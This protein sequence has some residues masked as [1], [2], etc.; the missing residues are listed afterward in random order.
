MFRAPKNKK[1]LSRIFAD[2][3]KPKILAMIPEVSVPTV[4]RGMQLKFLPVM[5]AAHLELL[6]LLDTDKLVPRC[7]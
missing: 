7:C 2:N 3:S 6:N 4:F 1:A 5:Q